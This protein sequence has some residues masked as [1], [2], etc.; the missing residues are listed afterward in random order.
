VLPLPN[1]L[2]TQTVPPDNVVRNGALAGRQ[3]GTV[4]L[5]VIKLPGAVQITVKDDGPGMTG[6][7]IAR[8]LQAK[9]LRGWEISS[10]LGAGTTAVREIPY[11]R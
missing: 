4:N 6:E 8:L 1:W 10:A 5:F 11:W 3:G 2:S 9:G 7:Q